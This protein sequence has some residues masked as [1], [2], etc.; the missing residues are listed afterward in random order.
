M[1]FQEL[2]SCF[3]EASSELLLCVACLNPDDLFASFNKEKLLR[4]TQFY[5]NDFSTV[6]FSTL[7]NQLETYILD[8]RSSNE[9]ATIKGIGQLVEKLVKMKSIPYIR[10]FIN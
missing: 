4:L 10:W 5:P 9:F 8:T 7:D 2:N 6:K 1:Q 3:N